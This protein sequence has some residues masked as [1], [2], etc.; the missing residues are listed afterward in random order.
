[1]RTTARW[2]LLTLLLTAFAAALAAYRAGRFADAA[3]MFDRLAAEDPPSRVFAAR[4]RR[5][6]AAPP[7]LPWEAVTVLETK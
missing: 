4:A 3:A 7:P 2:G 1:M 6:V 5:Y